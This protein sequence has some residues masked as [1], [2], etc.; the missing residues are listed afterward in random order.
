MQNNKR[1]RLGDGEIGGNGNG[2]RGRCGRRPPASPSCRLYL[3]AGSHRGHRGHRGLRPGGK[4][5]CG[6]WPIS[7]RAGLR[8]VGA[9][10]Y[11]SERSG[12]GGKAEKK[13]EEH[14]REGAWAIG[15]AGA[16]RSPF[17]TPDIDRLIMN[18]IY[19]D[20]YQ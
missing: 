4:W 20:I 3:R 9:R 8:L 16:T 10:S 18:E 13:D 1:G 17:A 5:E 12:P 7:L 14:R 15:R 6:L 2:V 11:A 19:Y